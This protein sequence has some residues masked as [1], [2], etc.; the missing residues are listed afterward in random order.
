M[1][2]FGVFVIQVHR[3][4]DADDLSALLGIS[5]ESLYDR[6]ARGRAPPPEIRRGRDLRWRVE[7]IERWLEEQREVTP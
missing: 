7:A 5:R 3:L 2:D 1:P 4:L 6:R